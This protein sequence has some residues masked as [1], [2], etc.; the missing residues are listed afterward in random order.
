M[1]GKNFRHAQRIAVELPIKMTTS[2]GVCFDTKT[3]DFSNSGVF[4]IASDAV[5]RAALIHSIVRVQFQGTNFRPPVMSAMV[6]RY[7]EVGLALIL[8]DTEIAGRH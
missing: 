5:K 8:L 6:V 1:L 2:D 7:T 4:L 3:W